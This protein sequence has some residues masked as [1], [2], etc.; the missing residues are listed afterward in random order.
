MYRTLVRSICSEVHLRVRKYNSESSQIKGTD[1]LLAGVTDGT[2]RL[3]SG[4]AVHPY[5]RKFAV[6]TFRFFQ[7]AAC[8]QKGKKPSID[9]SY[10][11][12]NF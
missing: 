12:V 8:R 1:F 7:S 9:F 5:P 2:I 6:R 10:P 3:Q 4:N 11:F